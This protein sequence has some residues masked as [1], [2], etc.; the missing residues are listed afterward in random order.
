[1]SGSDL[2]ATCDETHSNAASERERI[3]RHLITHAGTLTTAVVAAIEEKYPWYAK[4]GAQERSWINLLASNGINNFA[5]WFADTSDADMDPSA[6]FK[7]APRR[8]ARTI[9]LRQTVDLVRTTIEVV[10]YQIGVLIPDPDRKILENAILRYSRE[11]AFA[12]A[13]IYAGTAESRVRWDERMEA[14]IVD[15]IIREDRSDELLSRAA[16]LGWNT[17][18][19]VAVAVG[20]AN[21]QGNVRSRLHVGAE[22]LGLNTMSA[23][24]G[25]R[26][27]VLLSDGQCPDELSNPVNWVES[28][29]EYFAKGTIVVGHMAPDLS[30]VYSSAL[31]ALSGSRVVKGWRDAPRVVGTLSLIHI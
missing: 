7:S 22:D 28:I 11:V 18:A 24:H 6:I 12:S 29:S 27:V 1:M 14:L 3:A 8:L 4:L 17:R 26:L 19:Q 9:S 13:E 25:D 5:G 21:T 10:E 23:H 2:P 31:S 30:Q 15:A 20:L 16:T